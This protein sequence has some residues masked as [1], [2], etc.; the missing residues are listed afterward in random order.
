MKFL[1]RLERKFGDYALPHV[2]VYIIV[3][4]GLTYL[5]ARSQPEY[6]KKLVLS[7]DRNQFGRDLGD[8]RFG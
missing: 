2:T 3:L 8:G 4:Q 7:H 6:V 5:I 1:N